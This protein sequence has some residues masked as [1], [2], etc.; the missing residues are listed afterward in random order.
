M[1]TTL[2]FL[3]PV[4]MLAVA[5]SLCFVGC[6]LQTHG[7]AQPYS[8]TIIASASENG[9]VAYWPLSDLIGTSS[10]FG[11]LNMVGQT[12]VAG[13]IFDGHSGNYTI[14]P[15][16][17]SFTAAL[18]TSDPLNTSFVT[19]KAS[20]VPGDA[21]STEN[22]LPASVDFQ[23]GFV[24]IPWSTQNPQTTP[25]LSEFTLEAWFAL[26][27]AGSGFARALFA[28]I[29]PGDTAGFAL[30]IDGNGDWLVFLGNAAGGTPISTGVQATPG[31]VALTFN[32]SSQALALWN[33]PESDTPALPTPVWPNASS[34]SPAGLSY[35]AAD[36]S[37]L[38]QVFIGAGATDEALRTM[39][40]V[41]GAPLFPFMG[42]IQ[43][44]ALY[45]MALDANTLQDHFI[46]GS[47]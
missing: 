15:A 3:V 20:I 19:R 9:L 36:P 10:T 21:G 23:G 16:Y 40:G 38:T 22:S 47:G 43:S 17:P 35:V 18:G 11:T 7:E 4:G 34:P 8:D 45:S 46:N 1:N 28:A 44:V 26:D 42:Q 31:Y 13:D 24:N 30:L 27:P 39:G 25:T 37:Q 33:N 2:F 5:W 12:A 14:P 29:I 32:K 41:M 6:V